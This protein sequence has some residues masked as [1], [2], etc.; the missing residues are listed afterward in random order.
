MEPTQAGWLPA[1]DSDTAVD[2]EVEPMADQ[3]ARIAAALIHMRVE[4]HM[5]VADTLKSDNQEALRHRWAVLPIEVEALH[6]PVPAALRKQVVLRIPA[7]HIQARHHM[8]GQADIDREEL[9]RIDNSVGV[10]GIPALLARA[11]RLQVVGLAAAP[12]CRWCRSVRH[13]MLL[14]A[15]EHPTSLA[16]DRSFSTLET[17]PNSLTYR[18]S[19][20]HQQPGM[21]SAIS[22]SK[23][24]E[25]ESN[26]FS[27]RKNCD[28]CSLQF[29]KDSSFSIVQD[30]IVKF[31]A[32]AK[33]GLQSQR[34]L[35]KNR[36]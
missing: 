7:H 19:S 17:N 33:T 1:V 24:L 3:P 27:T 6:I 28:S 18:Q 2:T 15:A 36:S 26:Y 31:A 16:K 10:V 9:A 21:S 5:V 12:H 25:P 32:Q 34:R 4:H 35:N 22:P 11:A 20:M 30:F 29:E 13:P 14:E 8:R 23:M